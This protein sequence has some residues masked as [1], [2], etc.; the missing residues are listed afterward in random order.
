MP[1]DMKMKYDP[2]LALPWAML[3]AAAKPDAIVK[4]AQT[5]R[6]RAYYAIVASGGSE[7]CF[8]DGSVDDYVYYIIEDEDFRSS[9]E[10]EEWNYE[11]ERNYW[12]RS[13]DRLTD[14]RLKAFLKTWN[15]FMCEERI[16]YIKKELRW[17]QSLLSIQQK[18]V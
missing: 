11:C 7:M 9:L 13:E 8:E 1:E 14:P 3:P 10:P 18:R 17:V 12:C 15:K 4:A 2:L 5:G 6:E 16:R